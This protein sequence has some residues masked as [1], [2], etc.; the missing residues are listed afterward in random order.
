L[1]AGN[2]ILVT[3]RAAIVERKPY[4]NGGESDSNKKVKS[5]SMKSHIAPSIRGG[6][7]TLIS[8]ILIFCLYLLVLNSINDIFCFETTYNKVEV[9]CH[10]FRRTISIY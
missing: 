4:S 3:S 1:K 6:K 8:R 10:R 7:Q 5:I 9:T 2:E